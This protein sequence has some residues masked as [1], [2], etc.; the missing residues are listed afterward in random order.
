[1]G[2]QKLFLY[3]ISHSK[4]DIKTHTY[5]GGTAN[6]NKRIKQHNNKIPGGPRITRRASPFWK[7]VMI[8]QLPA[9]RKYSSK[10]LKKEWKQSSRG[11]ESRIRKGLEL[12]WK[13]NL[14]V[15]ITNKENMKIKLLNQLNKRWTKGSNPKIVLSNDEWGKIIT[16]ERI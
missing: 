1:M 15:Y 12:A 7:P 5:I 16:G 2:K 10:I 11:L 14:K 4:K 8:L 13:Y 9:A 3:L 6:F